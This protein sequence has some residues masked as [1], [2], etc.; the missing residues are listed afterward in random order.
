MSMSAYEDGISPEMASIIGPCVAAVID[1]TNHRGERR[2]RTIL[3]KYWRM[4]A[5]QWHRTLGW[6]CYAVDLDDGREKGFAMSG[7]HSWIDR[8]LPPERP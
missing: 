8:Q 1:Y 6:I 7:I 3:P 2:E 5:N 4:E